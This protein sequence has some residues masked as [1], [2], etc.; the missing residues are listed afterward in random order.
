MNIFLTYLVMTHE[1]F[2]KFLACHSEC[3]NIFTSALN[4]YSLITVYNLYQLLPN[5]F[6]YV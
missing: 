5:A 4:C 3:V 6:I 1:L 2:L